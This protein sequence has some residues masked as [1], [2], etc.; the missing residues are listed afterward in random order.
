M[1]LESSR[2]LQTKHECVWADEIIEPQYRLLVSN[3]IRAFQ[4]TNPGTVVTFHGIVFHNLLT[5]K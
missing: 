3:E 4:A 5:E 1:G 2:R